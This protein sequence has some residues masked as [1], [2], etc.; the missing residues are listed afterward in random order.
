M[1]KKILEKIKQPAD[2]RLLE[3]EELQ[4]LAS[5]I[6]ETIIDVTSQ[7]G[8]HVGPNLG[9]VELSIAL[10]LV[11]DSPDDKFCW[12][13]SHQGY[14]HKLLT[15]R[16]DSKF[17]KLR[18][19]D[20]L[21]GFLNRKERDFFEKLSDVSGIGPKTALS[22]IGHMDSSALEEAISSAN[23]FLLSKVPGIGKKTAERLI[24][25]LKDKIKTGFKG[26][27]PS[28]NGTE[29]K[30]ED[31]TVSDALNALMNLGYNTMQAQ[32]AIKKA[33]EHTG[34]TPELSKLITTA[35]KGI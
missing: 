10:H 34:E 8:G 12:D 20:G 31:N 33:L 21:S 2:L 18:G 25:E 23:I 29:V 26:D 13:V 1:T 6:R 9:V 35:L 27:L 7:K 28:V 15:G 16:N 14:V 5:E 22:L 4:I 30:E 19:T 17:Q 11:F 32:K 24:V 3:E